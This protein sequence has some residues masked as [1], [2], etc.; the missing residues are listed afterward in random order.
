MIIKIL[1]VDPGETTGV[2]LITVVGGK[3]TPIMWTEYPLNKLNPSSVMSFKTQHKPD[4][5]GIETVVATGRLNK[6]KVN[7]IKAFDRWDITLQETPLGD[8]VYVTPEITK[9]IN[10][11]VPKEITGNHNRDAYRIAMA[12]LGKLRGE[13][14][15]GKTRAKTNS[16]RSSN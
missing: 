10:V 15:G 16:S 7:Q 3:V 14:D 9:K 11:E 13:Q 4:Y 6:D 1:G 2:C 12:V 5:I 8:I